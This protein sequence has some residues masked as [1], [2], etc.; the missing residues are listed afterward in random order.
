M[1][2]S[3]A[4]WSRSC[5][6]R[7]CLVQGVPASDS[8]LP[9]GRILSP[10]R[11]GPAAP[12]PHQLRQAPSSDSVD[13]EPQAPGQTCFRSYSSA[14]PVVVYEVVPNDLL[15]PAM[16][17]SSVHTRLRQLLN[18][19]A[20]ETLAPRA[21]PAPAATRLADCAPSNQSNQCR[22]QWPRAEP[23]ID[24]TPMQCDECRVESG[25]SA[26]NRVHAAMHTV[27]TVC[28]LYRLKGV[29]IP[30]LLGIPT[31]ECTLHL[32]RGESGS[33]KKH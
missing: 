6:S 9:A 17:S 7:V 30:T 23:C 4:P 12:C 2:P 20:P 1:V 19:L 5:V 10:R 24:C 21:H 26:L 18:E 13:R 11:R 27:M 32:Q 22:A 16:N 3:S 14:A 31:G 33:N 8:L 15:R 28:T 25:A 29:G